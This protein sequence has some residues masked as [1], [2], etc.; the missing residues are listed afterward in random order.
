M[1]DSVAIKIVIHPSYPNVIS[2]Y[3]L[4]LQWIINLVSITDK[5]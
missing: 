2:H 1:T 3:S 5:A 4:L